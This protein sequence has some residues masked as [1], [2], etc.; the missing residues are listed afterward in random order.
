MSDSIKTQKFL[1]KDVASNKM[2]PKTEMIRIVKN[3]I[4]KIFIDQ[5]KKADGR[6]VYIKPF[7]EAVDKIKKTHALDRN[8]KTKVAEEIY[9][10]LIKEINDNW[11]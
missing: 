1:R 3:K 11:N 10:Q 2:Y 6:G 7:L 5:S 8:F 4:G 9:N